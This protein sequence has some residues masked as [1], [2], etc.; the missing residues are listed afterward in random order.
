MASVTIGYSLWNSQHGAAKEKA[1]HQNTQQ[2]HT[3]QSSAKGKA[4]WCGGHAWL[5]LQPLFPEPA[6]ALHMEEE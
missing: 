5:L 6:A 1:H 2:V 3:Q 4:P